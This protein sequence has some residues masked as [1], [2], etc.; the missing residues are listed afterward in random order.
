ME[1]LSPNTII[2]DSKTDFGNDGQGKSYM[3]NNYSNRFSGPVTAKNALL[4]SLNIPAIKSFYVAGPQNVVTLANKMGLENL[5]PE[6]AYGLSTALGAKEVRL[7]DHAGAM[8]IFGNEGQKVEK[9]AILKIYDQNGEIIE[10]N[11]EFQ[12]SE[13]VLDPNIANMVNYALTRNSGSLHIPGH[14]I[15]AKTGT[16]NVNHQ[17]KSFPRDTWTVGWTPQI[18][19]AVWAGNNDGSFLASN[20]VSTANAG[21]AFKAFMIEALKKY[22]NSGFGTPDLTGIRGGGSHSLLYH[23]DRK[24]DPQYKNWEKAIRGAQIARAKK[25][26]EEAEAKAK[27]KKKQEEEEESQIQPVPPEPPTSDLCADI[28]CQNGGR[29]SAGVC[30]CIDGYTGTNC[31]ISP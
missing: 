1:G 19:I 12:E 27:A 16:S 14:E 11:S 6:E 5:N 2:Y 28:I 31:E 7:I 4:K 20:A 25:K 21:P 13:K 30:E 29:C 10:D 22:P 15:A 8:S 18:A 24:K 3:P 17:G 23:L 26:K 9:T